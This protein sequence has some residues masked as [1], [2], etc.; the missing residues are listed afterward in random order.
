[1]ISLILKIKVI[2]DSPVW[3]HYSIDNVQTGI[4]VGIVCSG[5]VKPLYNGIEFVLYSCFQKS[6]MTM[7][8]GFR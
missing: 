4:Q 5:T 2:K 1:M 3:K 8:K 6:S 7:V